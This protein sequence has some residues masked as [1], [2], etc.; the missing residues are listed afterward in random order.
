MA[1]PQAVLA[2]PSKVYHLGNINSAA[3]MVEQSRPER[4]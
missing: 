2:Q 1:R 3:P 4:F